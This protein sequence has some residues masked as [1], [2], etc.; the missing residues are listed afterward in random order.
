MELVY[1]QLFLDEGG[2]RA[3]SSLRGELDVFGLGCNTVFTSSSVKPVE[4]QARVMIHLLGD[5]ERMTET[6]RQVILGHAATAGYGVARIIE[7]DPLLEPEEA[8]GLLL[9]PFT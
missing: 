6:D 8:F 7:D 3:W 1:V 9:A 5:F 4:R 2:A